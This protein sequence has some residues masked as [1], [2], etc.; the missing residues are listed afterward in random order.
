MKH[1]AHPPLRPAPQRPYR[2]RLAS[3]TSGAVDRNLKS[4]R[5]RA[6]RVLATQPSNGR[7]K[8]A[9]HAM[10]DPPFVRRLTSNRGLHLVATAGLAVAGAVRRSSYPTA[11]VSFCATVILGL[12]VLRYVL[13]IGQ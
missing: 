7:R 6:D 4:R 3:G 12:L 13:P 11:L 10:D 8:V 9:R 5:P 1:I 2:S